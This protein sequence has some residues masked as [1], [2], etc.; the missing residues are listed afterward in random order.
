MRTTHASKFYFTG[1]DAAPQSKA[2]DPPPL[3]R[4]LARERCSGLPVQ[5]LLQD[6][7]QLE[8][9]FDKLVSVGM[10]EHVGPS[11]LR[12]GCWTSRA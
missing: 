9:S 8:G 11:A 2:F 1:R 7:R 6:Y 4:R 5:I 12:R 3:L 10:F